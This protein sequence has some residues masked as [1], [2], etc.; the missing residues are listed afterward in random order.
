MNVPAD[1]IQAPE[2]QLPLWLLLLRIL[3][4]AVQLILVFWLGKKGQMFFY[5][6]F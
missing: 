5:Q 1:K 6:G 3:W 4:I 2:K